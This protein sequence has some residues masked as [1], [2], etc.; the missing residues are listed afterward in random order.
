[1]SKLYWRVQFEIMGSVHEGVQNLCI[2]R[3]LPSQTNALRECPEGSRIFH[4]C[5]L[6]VV[7]IDT[8]LDGAL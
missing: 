2:A 8:L 4:L 6:Y 7:R 5:C 3:L 1:M